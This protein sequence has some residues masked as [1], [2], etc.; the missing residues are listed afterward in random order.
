MK[1]EVET[2]SAVSII[3]LQKYKQMFRRGIPLEKT[4]V[5]LKTYCGETMT[6]EGIINV[7][8]QYNHQTKVLPLFVVNT[9]GPALFGRDWLHEFDLDW[10]VVKSI[11]KNSK[12][13][14]QKKLK[15]LL[16]EYSEIFQEEIGTLKSTKAKV[17]L[18][19]GYEAKFCKARPVPYALN[20]RRRIETPRK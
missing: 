15:K 12:K 8:I 17:P 20:G 11:T 4:E 18:K 14:T 7:P 16:D 1:M 19:E 3:P 9:A 6:P 5:T 13:D 10:K 2:G